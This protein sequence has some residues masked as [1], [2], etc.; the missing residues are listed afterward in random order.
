MPSYRLVSRE[1]H[2]CQARP[3]RRRRS[4]Q[5]QR[6]RRPHELRAPLLLPGLVAESLARHRSETTASVVA[7][8]PAR[9]PHSFW[10]NQRWAVG[11]RPPR[12]CIRKTIAADAIACRDIK[13]KHSGGSHAS[14]GRC[15]LLKRTAGGAGCRDM[16]FVDRLADSGSGTSS[17]VWRL[18]CRDTGRYGRAVLGPPSIA[19]R[20]LPPVSAEA[21]A[22]VQERVAHLVPIAEI[23]KASL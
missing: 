3:G 13:R 4:N 7:A 14:R 12:P 8:T 21:L 23:L 11:C 19:L 9:R 5:T 6:R 17:L 1:K 10:N 15:P 16:E 2:L 18:G 20:H 22:R